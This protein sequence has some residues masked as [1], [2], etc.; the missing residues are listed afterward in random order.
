[1]SGSGLLV[2]GGGVGHEN[3]VL[4]S[5]AGLDAVVSCQAVI[6]PAPTAFEP[7]VQPAPIIGA[8]FLLRKGLSM[9]SAWPSPEPSF[10]PAIPKE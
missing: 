10:G 3:G 7:R 4:S 9:L 6:G 5:T 1:M 8:A 2:K